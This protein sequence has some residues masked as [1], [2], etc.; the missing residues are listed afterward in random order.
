MRAALR[1]ALARARSAVQVGAMLKCPQSMA[2]AVA[3]LPPRRF[4]AREPIERAGEDWV[5]RHLP[6]ERDHRGCRPGR[7]RRRV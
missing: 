4:I 6:L 7:E 1:A 2:S 5:V 3:H